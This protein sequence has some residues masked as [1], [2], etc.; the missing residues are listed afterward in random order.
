[1]LAI[2]YPDTAVTF[3]T[4]CPDFSPMEIKEDGTK[5]GYRD[6]MGVEGWCILWH[7]HPNMVLDIVWACIQMHSWTLLQFQLQ[8]SGA[9]GKCIFFSPAAKT[10]LDSIIFTVLLHIFLLCLLFSRLNKINFL[11]ISSKSKWSRSLTFIT[12]CWT[13]SSFYTS[14]QNWR[15]QGYKYFQ[16]SFMLYP[17]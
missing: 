6:E 7:F 4:T 11:S 10:E 2:D 15:T 5:D 16:C 3:P 1:M 12:L 14:F 13:L 9:L 8:Y 17:A